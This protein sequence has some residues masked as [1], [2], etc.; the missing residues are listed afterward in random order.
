MPTPSAAPVVD[1][2]A[3]ANGYA[4]IAL[5]KVN[6]AESV[7]DELVNALKQRLNAQYSEADYRGLIESLKANAKIH[8]PVEG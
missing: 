1:T 7:S 3:L 2:V 4:V 8:Y 5:D 6:A